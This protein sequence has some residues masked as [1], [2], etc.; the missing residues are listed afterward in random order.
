MSASQR[1]LPQRLAFLPAAGAGRDPAGP[2]PGRPR[3]L[4]DGAAGP[5]LQSAGR[6]LGTLGRG[7]PGRPRGRGGREPSSQDFSQPRNTPPNVPP[8]QSTN[9]NSAFARMRSSP[10]LASVPRTPLSGER[11]RGGAGPRRRA[12]GPGPGGNRGPPSAARG[13]GAAAALLAGLGRGGRT[14][15]HPARPR[16]D[17]GLRPPPPTNVRLP[18]R[19]DRLKERTQSF[20]ACE[21]P[22]WY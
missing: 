20:R 22:P 15:A 10:S 8:P 14:P 5:G 17:H 6:G 4:L 11:V 7:P 9:E 19:R 13:I 1:P 3:G 2:G 16:S 21:P 12:P 18:P